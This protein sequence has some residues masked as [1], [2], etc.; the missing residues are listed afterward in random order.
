MA[1]SSDLRDWQSLYKQ[2]HARAEREAGG[3]DPDAYGWYVY[4][5]DYYRVR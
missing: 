4:E 2:I 5:F 1:P 3:G